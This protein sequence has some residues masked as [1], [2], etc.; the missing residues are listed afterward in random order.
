MSSDA[1]PHSDEK[2][3]FYALGV[4]LAN[5]IGKGQLDNLLSEEEMDLVIDGFSSIMKGTNLVDGQTVL[6]KYGMELNQ[7]LTSRT[8]S[9]SEKIKADGED[10]IANFLDC[11]DEAV[12]TDSGL[13]YYSMVEGTGAQPTTADSVEV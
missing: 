4:N 5:Q 13:V 2:M 11:N 12:K 9:V 8:A 10:F 3:P 6:M 7:I 1:M